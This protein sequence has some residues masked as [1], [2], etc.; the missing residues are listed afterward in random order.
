M[1]IAHSAYTKVKEDYT[2]ELSGWT[3]WSDGSTD[4]AEG[5]DGKSMYRPWGIR[6]WIH[7]HPMQQLELFPDG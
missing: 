6:D 1:A 5:S 7:K 2:Q 3:Y 4:Y